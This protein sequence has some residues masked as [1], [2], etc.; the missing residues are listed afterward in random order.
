MKRL[1]DEFGRGERDLPAGDDPA[2]PGGAGN[3]PGR[4]GPPPLSGYDSA[5]DLYAA[6]AAAR[7]ANLARLA[8]AAAEGQSEASQPARRRKA[9][10]PLLA[11]TA[12]VVFCAARRRSK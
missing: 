9:V 2:L 7:R 11:A 12:A 8:E 4:R 5:D 10:W 3:G 1:E 6:M